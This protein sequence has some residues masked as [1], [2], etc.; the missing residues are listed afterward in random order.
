MVDP[1]NRKLIA[2]GEAAWGEGEGPGVR[3]LG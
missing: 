2:E 3:D 1:T